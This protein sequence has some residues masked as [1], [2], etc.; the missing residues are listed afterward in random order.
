[1]GYGD[2]EAR[3]REVELVCVAD[4]ELDAI[5]DAIVGCEPLRGGDELRALI[6]SRDDAGKSVSRGERARHDARAAAEVHDVCGARQVDELQV[7]LAVRQE[8]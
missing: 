7:G 5:A 2:V 4:D 8:R 1:V 3:S 6:D